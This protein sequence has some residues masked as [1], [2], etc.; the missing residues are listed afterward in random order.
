MSIQIALL[1]GDGIGP[2]VA[3]EA[4]KVLRELV[5]IEVVDG[6]IGGAAIDATAHPLPDET[7]A[8]YRRVAA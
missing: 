3:F 4:T 6:L 8:L 5:S 2:E 7:I 1:G